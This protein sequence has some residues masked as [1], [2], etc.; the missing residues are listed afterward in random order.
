M[1]QPNVP[2]VKFRN[3]DK[4]P[5]IAF[6]VGVLA[7]S[8]E[9]D[10][11]LVE[12]LKMAIRNGYRHFDVSESYQTEP[13]VGLALKAFPEIP[14][15]EFF[16]TS[17][18]NPGAGFAPGGP[19]AEASIKASLEKF[20]LDYLDL[21]LIHNPWFKEGAISRSEAWTQMEQVQ[22]KG[23]AKHIGVSNFKPHTI[24]EILKTAKVVPE[25]NQF[26][27]HPNLYDE[28][29]ASVEYDNGHHIITEAY[30]PLATLSN[31]GDLFTHSAVL[32]V[33]EK[34]AAKYHVNS[35]QILLQWQ[36]QKGIV[37]VT[38]SANP[39]RQKAQLEFP[40]E[41]TPE[42]DQA[43]IGA[44]GENHMRFFGFGGFRK[45]YDI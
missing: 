44:G 18:I 28:D 29:W 30:S 34:L 14:R 19:G 21:Y 45:S 40:F 12:T 15:S 16:I 6:G 7:P 9:V 25:V 43:I 26:E 38:S 33:V 37:V 17:K 39:E 2:F 8:P 4:M 32:P 10:P 5:A 27:F 23:L 20:G 3:G 22:A 41:L 24:D 13:E 11:K 36:L 31:R 35:A 42:E 1:P